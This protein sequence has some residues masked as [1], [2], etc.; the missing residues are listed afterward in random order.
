[1]SCSNLAL[2]F[3]VYKTVSCRNTNLRQIMD[4]YRILTGIFFITDATDN[5]IA[6]IHLT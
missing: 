2:I 4:F 1:M 3:A 5:L 6:S